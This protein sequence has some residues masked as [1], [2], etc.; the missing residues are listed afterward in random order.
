LAQQA[1]LL[2]DHLQ[3]PCAA[4]EKKVSQNCL[5]LL[6]GFKHLGSLSKK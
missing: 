1:F 2:E 5:Q 3:V 6:R 4:Q